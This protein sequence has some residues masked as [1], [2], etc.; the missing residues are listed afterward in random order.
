M[1]DRLAEVAGR[2]VS[3]ETI[4]RLEAY[5]A[6]VTEESRRQNLVSASTLG[7]IWDRH[8]RDSAQLIRFEPYA[9]ASWVDIGSGAGLPGIVVAC[10]VEGSVTLVEPRRLRADFL[11]RVCESLGLRASVF[12]GKAERAQGTYDVIT[13][14]AVGN[15]AKLLKISAHLSTGNSRWVLPKGRSAEE[16]LV[17]AQQAWQGAFHVEQSATDPESRIVVA[18]GVRAKR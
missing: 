14:R 17:E 3:R 12:A 6:L 10:L 1:R 11:H 15:L 9:G 16:E 5:V 18:A 7:D 8:I 4:E 2:D 13:A